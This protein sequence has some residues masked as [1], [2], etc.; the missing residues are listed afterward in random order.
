MTALEILRRCRAAANEIWEI[1]Q[2][3]Q[4]RKVAMA[5]ASSPQVGTEGRSNV[6]TDKMAQMA[7]DVDELERMRQDRE[8]ARRA[9]VAAG[10]ILLD[11][12]PP[13]DSSLMTLYYIK[14][15]SLSDIARQTRY[16]YSYVRKIKSRSEKAL[17]AIDG[18]EVRKELPE[19][20]L[21]RYGG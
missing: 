9:E 18:E 20:Y 10:C 21:R 3:I 14:S 17:A 1:E 19:W 16:A 4:N 11:R 15:L 12:L 7:A 8:D 5:S 6:H 2:R 13:T